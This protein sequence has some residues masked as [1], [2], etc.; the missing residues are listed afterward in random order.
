MSDV[1][2]PEGQKHGAYAAETGFTH[3]GRLRGDMDYA[4]TGD[5]APRSRVGAGISAIRSKISSA[6]E[7]EERY[8][9]GILW[10]P[11]AMALG[12]AIWFGA[13]RNFS[14]WPIVMVF[15]L[16]LVLV[17]RLGNLPRWRYWALL[18]CGFLVGMLASAAETRRQAT[19]LLDSP[20]TTRIVGTVIAR[21]LDD[22]G[23]RRYTVRL[24][25]TDDPHIGRPPERVRLLARSQHDPIQI[26]EG[27]SG[28]ARLQPPSGPALPGGFD[29]AFNAYFNGL[30]AF[31]Y[32]YGRPEHSQLE[33][34][35]LNRSIGERSL[36]ELARVRE[37]I[38]IRM[39]AALPGD[40]GAF[41]GALAVADR[42]AMSEA[43][44]EALR[45]SGLAHVLAIS[46]L[47]MALVAGT[48]FFLVRVGFSLF[49]TVSQ[50][51]PVKKAAALVSL[52][53]ATAYLLISGA[54]VSTQR[55]WIMLAIVLVAVLFDR[56]ALTLRN[57]ALAAICIILLTPSAV[58]G[59]GFQM[60]FAATAGL[61][62]AY[63]WW[64]RRGRSQTTFD[65]QRLDGIAGLAVLFLVG[66]AMTSLVAGLST[67]PFAT[68]HFH[69]VA[70]LGLIANLAAMPIVSLVVMPMGLI[71]VVVMPFGLEYWPL[72]MM[73]AGLEGVLSVA[74]IVQD[75]GGLIVTG[76]IAE[77]VFLALTV[78]LL[79]LV[80]AR[81]WLRYGGLLIVGVTLALA[82][83]LPT[84]ADPELLV[85]EDGRLVALVGPK[86]LASNRSRP[87]RFIFDQWRRAL[88]RSDHLRPGR[89]IYEEQDIAATAWNFDADDGVGAPK[90]AC[91]KNAL[92]LGRT[93]S[94]R[95]V[96]IVENLA[97]LGAA[98][99]R[100]DIV[101]TNRRINMRACLS[102]AM[103][104][105]GKMLRQTGAVEFYPPEAGKEPKIITTIGQS[106]RPWTVHRSYDW[107]SRSFEFHRPE[108]ADQ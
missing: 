5:D 19:T 99:D 97:L 42:R 87:S 103:L 30:G 46:G 48:V 107:R 49:P 9:H 36:V 26:G 89:L 52:F 90:F 8:G 73:G 77:G 72:Q 54:S 47:H 28:L 20:V 21:D 25:D 102:G 75:F 17:T 12:A 38:A 31:G 60:S 37:Q 96:A 59:P 78:G 23:R 62:A 105:T 55:A 95:T 94:G 98:C 101:I 76:R 81:S 10:L 63:A 85:S 40:A 58:V 66:L 6:L 7:E 74:R 64:R 108:W 1:R 51:F 15:A 82:L 67:A 70:S 50:A 68:Y 33:G 18:I 53:V 104:I 80:L 22:R 45:A 56:P 13:D 35:A 61:V 92:C 100:A 86:S 65:G 106:N 16:L 3:D 32:F 4:E 41:A 84:G 14:P 43:S 44:V 11:V 2:T 91:L 93:A 27:I 57:V 83:F 34:P 24:T 39:R 79:L 88:D 69:R 29:F 71:S